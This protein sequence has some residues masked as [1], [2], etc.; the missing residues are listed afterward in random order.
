M[1]TNTEQRK[2]TNQDIEQMIVEIDKGWT[3]LNNIHVS[4][5]HIWRDL[6]QISQ[7]LDEKFGISY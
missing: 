7:D 2:I 1:R 4:C 6:V 5:H 3:E